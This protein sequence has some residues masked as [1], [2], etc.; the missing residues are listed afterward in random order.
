MHLP[1][2]K[3]PS[4]HGQIVPMTQPATEETLEGTPV[5]PL[6]KIMPGKSRQLKALTMKAL[7]SQ[8]RAWFTNICCITLCPLA[9]VAFSAVFGIVISNLIQRSNPIEGACFV[10]RLD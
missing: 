1:P 7:S 10:D 5:Q 8:K 9:M 4:L 3:E 2:L 6:T